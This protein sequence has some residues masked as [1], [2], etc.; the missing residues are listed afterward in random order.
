[1]AGRAGRRLEYLP[2]A[3]ADLKRLQQDDPVL[4]A[5][6]GRI[7]A[8][9]AAGRRDGEPLSAM[10]A[11]GDLSD[12]RKIYF[13]HRNQPTHRIVLQQRPDGTLEV[14]LVVAVEARADAY[15]YL[16][17]AERLQRLPQPQQ[18]N[19]DR[20]RQ[21]RIAQRARRRGR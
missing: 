18:P 3:V 6:A 11:T 19:L 21:E 16:L 13:G 2:A 17:S 14:L 5:E 8:D 20:L 7:L 4:A 15:V 9:V 1:M 12:C 10:A